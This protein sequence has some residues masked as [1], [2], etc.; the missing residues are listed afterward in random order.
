MTIQDSGSVGAFIASIG[1]IVSLIYLALQT[2][3]NTQAVK[4]QTRSSITDQVLSIQSLMFQSENY[5]RAF[6]KHGSGE[7]LDDLEKDMLN[8]EAL[9]F[10]KHM[11][12]AQF[13]FESGLYDPAEYQAQRAIWALR[14]TNQS[15]WREAFEFYK[16]TL[17][18]RLV[19]Q[20]QL[21]VDELDQ[22]E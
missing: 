20:M 11:E 12:N 21:I 4:A 19:A 13:Q 2:R 10:F 22:G 3:S 17:S 8:R 6:L 7:P 14:L 15:Y 9:L 16:S 18:P 5:R 1:V